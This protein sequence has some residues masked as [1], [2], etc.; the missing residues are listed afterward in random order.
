MIE[1]WMQGR[2]SFKGGECRCVCLQFFFVCVVPLGINN[3]K[4][5]ENQIQNELIS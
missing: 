2:Y 5:I 4:P 3:F 1:Y